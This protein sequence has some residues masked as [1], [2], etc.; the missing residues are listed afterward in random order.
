M[1]TS[2][3]WLKEY[4]DINVSAKELCD[5]LTMTGSKVEGLETKGDNIK[6]V[7]VGKILEI[8]KHPNADKLVVTKVDVKDEILQIVT[9]ATN[10]KVGDIV[11]IAKDGSELPGN[12]KIKKGKLRDIESCGMMCSVGELGIPVDM[13][14]NQ[15]EN[16]IMILPE[17]FEKNLGEDI[18]KVLDL[19][20]EIIEFEITSN[21]PDCF[22]IEGLGRE[23]AV[24]LN[25]DFKDPHSDLEKINSEVKEEI[26]GL[27]VNIEAPDLCYRYIARVVENVKIAPSPEWM[28]KRLAACGVRSINNIVD[29]TNYVML[30]LG[31]PMH[32]F[33]I[34]SINGK[35]IIVRRAKE[36][37]KIITLDEIER[38]LDND[39]LVIAD[40]QK[41]V[42]IAGVMGG[43][44][45]EIEDNTKT[46]VFESAVFNG[47]NVRKTAKKLQLRTEASSRYEKGL[48]QENAERAV[49]RAVQLVKMLNAGTEVSGKIDVYPTK[50]EKRK[51]KFDEKVIN[52]LL[53]TNISKE[54]MINIFEKLG[55]KVE[56]NEVIVPYFRMDIEQVADLAEEV[57]RFY[58]YDK[59]CSTLTSGEST[60]GIKTKIQKIS[61]DIEQMLRYKGLSEVCTYGFISKQDLKKVNLTEDDIEENDIIHIKNPL[62]EDYSIMR[63]TTIPSMMSVLATNNYKKNKE[64]KLFEIA[65]IYKDPNNNIS[66][67]E[68]PIEEKI[69]TLG[70]YGE[71]I[72]F[73]NMKGIVENI[74]E[75]SNI[76]R[77][78]CVSNCD[79]PSYHPGRV[80]KMVVGNDVI[81]MFGEINQIVTENY[82]ISKRVYI[83]EISLEKLVK[84]SK[85][86]K[87]YTEV[88]KF[89][90]VERDIAVCVDNNIE[91]GQ[92]EKTIIKKS[93]GILED[94]KLFDIYKSEKL[95]LDKKS[96][97]FS[98]IFR[99]KEKTLTDEEINKTLEEI[100]LELKKVYNADLR[101]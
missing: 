73:Y 48:S 3:E 14:E 25:Q 99:S 41:P 71:N 59:L 88:A 97:A 64:V 32:A 87:K 24:S 9:G 8:E 47:G 91:V 84:Y 93:K 77:Y 36:N 35:H 85:D 22:S 7:V 80:A 65:R 55:S 20:E 46:V 23:T 57:A 33:D 78:E 95:G 61:D 51:I 96:I 45:S 70:L 1:K 39:M 60:I 90:A 5:I 56:N 38:N 67:G 83:A 62:S 98:L 15:I 53:G 27:K 28:V 50:Q 30:E 58:G 17:K 6:N 72:D 16:G 29:I 81:A 49:E 89:P 21:R 63:T 11:P 86:N 76:A 68:T 42:A 13:F 10:I 18:V 40:E 19:K 92:I 43:M 2:I 82:D 12:I 37:E 44:N 34:N 66:K 101:K 94:I 54:E 69:I 52:K 31:Q 26:H 4:S 74:L 79:N 75:V 100:I